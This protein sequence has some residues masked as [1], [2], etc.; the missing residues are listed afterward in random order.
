MAAPATAPLRVHRGAARPL[1]LAARPR[2]A[3]APRAVHWLPA[4]HR[5]PAH[6][7]CISDARVQGPMA[8]GPVVL[9]S[10]DAS[11][12]ADRAC[13]PVW[14]CQ[15]GRAS[16]ADAR[17]CRSSGCHRLPAPKSEKGQ[18]WRSWTRLWRFE[19]GREWQTCAAASGGAARRRGGGRAQADRP[20]GST[21]QNKKQ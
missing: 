15:A 4:G 2:E 5:R 1:A 19:P 21:D 8:C 6:V 16:R 14:K 12:L 18:P 20:N 7:G 3:K 17:C 11:S 10:A 9:C 13:G